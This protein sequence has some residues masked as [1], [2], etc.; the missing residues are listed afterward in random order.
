MS[1]IT[2]LCQNQGH[3]V[4]FSAVLLEFKIENVSAHQVFDKNQV[5]QSEILV[6]FFQKP[7]VL[8]HFLFQI[9]DQIL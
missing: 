3:W 7:D 9:T 2:Y 4:S 5:K 8:E 1:L 6:Y